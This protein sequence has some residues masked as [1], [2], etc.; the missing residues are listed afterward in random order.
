MRRVFY[1][2]LAIIYTTLS[3]GAPSLLHFCSHEEVFHL[4][5]S[6]HEHE[7][8]AC[9]HSSEVDL[10][11]NCHS[12]N[13]DHHEIDENDGCCA[14]SFVALDSAKQENKPSASTTTVCPPSRVSM[15]QVEE[16]HF[17]TLP[18]TTHAERGP[19]IYILLQRLV[20]YA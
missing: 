17:N 19:P 4:A 12:S 6:S 5:T 10:T 15:S 16:S 9:C 20:L 18:T 7:D 11:Q 13:E 1:V 8:T 14:S 3:T 2:L